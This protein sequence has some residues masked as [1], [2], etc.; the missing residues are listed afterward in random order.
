MALLD[1]IAKLPGAMEVRMITEI[2]L[3]MVEILSEIS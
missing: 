3:R 2:L 1:V